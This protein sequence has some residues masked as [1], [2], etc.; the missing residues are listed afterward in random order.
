MGARIDLTGQR[1]GRRIATKLCDTA[2]GRLWEVVCD[3]GDVGHASADS[4]RRGIANQCK[5]M[6]FVF[7]GDAWIFWDPD[8]F[9]LAGYEDEVLEPERGRL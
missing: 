5:K 6:R 4:L 1:F 2:R 3:C 8:I 9:K 7:G